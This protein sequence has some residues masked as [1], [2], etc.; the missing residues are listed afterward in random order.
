MAAS[1]LSHS[2]WAPASGGTEVMAASND[3]PRPALDGKPVTGPTMRSVAV[4]F[5]YESVTI[6]SSGRSVSSPMD[7]AI[8][9]VDPPSRQPVAESEGADTRGG[10]LTVNDHGFG[11]RP[12]MRSFPCRSRPETVAVYV[13][14]TL[15]TVRPVRTVPFPLHAVTI[16]DGVGVR[17]RR[18]DRESIGSPQR[19]ERGRPN[20]R[21]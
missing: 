18:T 11:T 13:V 1:P 2:N 6:R 21:P 12:G 9:T 4:P 8:V 20:G 19:R 3:P 15:R 14:F 7:H 10:S 17:G 16:E 5:Q